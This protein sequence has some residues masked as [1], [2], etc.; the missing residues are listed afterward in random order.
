MRRGFSAACYHIIGNT[1][2]FYWI[3]PASRAGPFPFWTILNLG[4]R[5]RSEQGQHSGIP[6]RS[7]SQVSAV[8][9]R[10]PLR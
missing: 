8:D 7:A 1:T 5:A 10:P 9:A 3:D 6:A 4:G 2:S